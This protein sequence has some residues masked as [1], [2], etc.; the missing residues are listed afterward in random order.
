MAAEPR[1]QGPF[2]IVCSAPGKEGGRWQLL[3]CRG[4][5]V[6]RLGQGGSVQGKG[7]PAA[8]QRWTLRRGAAKAW[9]LQK[10]GHKLPRGSDKGLCSSAAYNLLTTAI[11]IKRTIGQGWRMNNSYWKVDEIQV[12]AKRARL[13]YV[14]YICALTPLSALD[15]GVVTSA[16][17]PSTP[18]RRHEPSFC[19]QW[20]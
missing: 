18:V 13:M 14:I 5:E 17:A 9:N 19:A 15:Y 6:W 8:P 12:R 10:M 4:A 20:A 16:A 1:S 3:G 2:S 11:W 7:E